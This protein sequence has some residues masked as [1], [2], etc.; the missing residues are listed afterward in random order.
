MRYK[1]LSFL[2]IIFPNSSPFIMTE[3]EYGVQNY[4]RIQY[5]YAFF[6]IRFVFASVAVCNTLSSFR[7]SLI[8]DYWFYSFMFL[9]LSAEGRGE[10]NLMTGSGAT[11]WKMEQFRWPEFIQLMCRI[12]LNLHVAGTARSF[13]RTSFKTFFC[14]WFYSCCPL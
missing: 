9:S 8:R 2:E 1:T 4:S 5:A 11:N 12:G 7:F 6:Y 13:T 14:V 10:E 3:N